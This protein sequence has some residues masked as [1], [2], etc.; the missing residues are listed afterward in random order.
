[1]KS[2]YKTLNR[3]VKIYLLIFGGA[4]RIGLKF[5]QLPTSIRKQA[6][7]TGSLLPNNYWVI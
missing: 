1:M 4:T 5:V 2:I 6:T 7:I 3:F